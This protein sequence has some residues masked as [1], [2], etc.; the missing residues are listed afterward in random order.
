MLSRI[1]ENLYWIGRYVERAE[2]TA[3]LLDVNYHALVEAPIVVG[4]RGLVTEQWAPLLSITGD[5]QAFRAH[6][7]RADNRT[8]PEW[9][10]FHP[11]NPASIRSSLSRARENARTLRDRI[12]LEMW[13]ALNRA[14]LQLCFDTD[15]ILEQDRLHEYCVAVRETSHLFFGIAHATLLRD[16]GWYFLEAGQYLERADNL[17]RLLQI[18]YRRRIEHEPTAQG[19]ENHRGMALLKSVSAY[20]AFR[21]KYH[22]ALEPRRIAAFLLL[23]EHF[24]RSMRYS[25]AELH[26]TLRSIARL[27]PGT[28]LQPVREAGWLSA[29]LEYMTDVG[30]IIEQEAPGIAELLKSLAHISDVIS[31]TY[32]AYA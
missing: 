26:R 13:E 20:E 17:L 29:Q 28:S 19:L 7:E 4:A 6:Y 25:V 16:L 8:V 31:A 18:R 22:T 27:N 24:P 9:L 11:G 14:Y 5:E 1:A 15:Q 32:F 3:R 12:S 10:A 23:D 21:K 30:Q 2:N